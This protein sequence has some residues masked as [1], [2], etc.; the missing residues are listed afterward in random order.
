ML[1]GLVTR[2]HENT[3]NQAS[4]TWSDQQVLIGCDVR[5]NIFFFFWVSVL[6][7]CFFYQIT[8][9]VLILYCSQMRKKILILK[10]LILNESYH[11]QVNCAEG[12]KY[13]KGKHC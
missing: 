1:F 11:E 7:V 10:K 2:A 5:G 12:L 3:C 4:H 8:D 6:F 9:R 13:P